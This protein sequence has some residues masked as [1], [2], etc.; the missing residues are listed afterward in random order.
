MKS[1]FK[2]VNMNTEEDIN[3]IRKVIANNEGVVACQ[4]NSEKSEVSVVYDDYFITSDL[5]I[6][7]VENLGYAVI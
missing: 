7:S 2:V 3:K 4:I 5:L 6:Q 1:M